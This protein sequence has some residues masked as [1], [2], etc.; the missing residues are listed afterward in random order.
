M[1][2]YLVS[3]PPVSKCEDYSILFIVL[4]LLIGFLIVKIHSLQVKILE[5]DSQHKILKTLVSLT[6]DDDEV[7]FKG[8]KIDLPPSKKSTSDI[9]IELK[10]EKIKTIDKHEDE[11]EEEKDD[12]KKDDE[13]D[14]KKESDDKIEKE[15]SGKK[16]KLR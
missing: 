6:F 13:G 14:D 11:E 12:D 10:K 1:E 8:E 16:K 2:Y 3:S 15:S 9:F 4:L 5:I 7:D